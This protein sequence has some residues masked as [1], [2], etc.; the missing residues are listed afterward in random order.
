LFPE[1]GRGDSKINNDFGLSKKD[2]TNKNTM[3]GAIG[4]GD[5]SR[6]LVLKTSNGAIS[7]KKD[8]GLTSTNST[9]FDVD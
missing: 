9:D 2:K 3:K 7:L 4:E 6:T 5:I 1:P 8:K